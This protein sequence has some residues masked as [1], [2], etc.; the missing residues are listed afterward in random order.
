[1]EKASKWVKLNVGGTLFT[2]SK[3]T[4]VS[5]S[6][7][8]RAL[9]SGQMAAERDETGAYLIDRDGDLFRP[10]LA[11]LRAG[12]FPMPSSVGLDDLQHEIDFYQIAA[13]PSAPSPP[14]VARFGF[15]TLRHDDPL[16]P[17]DEQ[18]LMLRFSS[19]CRSLVYSNRPLLAYNGASHTVEG[20]VDSVWWD[21]KKTRAEDLL[22]HLSALGFEIVTT[23]LIPPAAPGNS[24]SV[25]HY[26]KVQLADQVGEEIPHR[27]GI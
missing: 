11:F 5:K 26:A 15:A 14:P 17:P 1:M 6:A 25:L 18:R 7:F 24:L 16:S 3:Q 8:F 19:S 10:V 20:D 4:L 13:T 27:D 9:F 23:A 2:T 22:E 12:R 21:P